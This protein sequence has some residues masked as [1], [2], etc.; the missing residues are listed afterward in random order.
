ME[1]WDHLWYEGKNDVAPKAAAILKSA[2]FGKQDVDD[3][4]ERFLPGNCY[5]QCSLR[6][7]W[8]TLCLVADGVHLMDRQ[9][10][11][12]ATPAAYSILVP[13]KSSSESDLHHSLKQE[14][15][16]WLKLA[17]G[18]TEV[19][20]EQPFYA[21]QCDVLSSCGKWIIECG[22]SRPSKVWDLFRHESS[23]DRS[24]VFFNEHGITVF[25][26]GPNLPTYLELK[27][28]RIFE[29][30]NKLESELL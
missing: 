29:I 2:G 25:R 10:P 26:A 28:K 13:R 8:A 19:F 7:I 16:E 3:L 30:A 21:G 17:H 12:I 5:P 14:A 20:Y 23:S 9:P 22:A 18:I 27:R 1:L 4:Y 11:Y 24:I 15:T 6:D